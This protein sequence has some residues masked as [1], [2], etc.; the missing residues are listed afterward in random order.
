MSCS[1]RLTDDGDDIVTRKMRKMIVDCHEQ[2]EKMTL[3]A[4]LSEQS[5]GSTKS[6]HRGV[7]AKKHVVL[8]ENNFTQNTGSAGK[9]HEDMGERGNDVNDKKN[10]PTPGSHPPSHLPMNSMVIQL[11]KFLLKNSMVVSH[12]QAAHHQMIDVWHVSKLTCWT[13]NCFPVTSVS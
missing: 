10:Q 11:I 2:E 5:S 4:S 1:N 12:S 6:D 3:D 9:D 8:D 13:Y 7:M